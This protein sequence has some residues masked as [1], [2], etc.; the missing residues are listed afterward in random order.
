MFRALGGIL[1]K[2]TPSVVKNKTYLINDG[3]FHTLL[4]LELQLHIYSFLN[5][6]ESATA[7]PTCVLFN[8]LHSHHQ[9]KAFLKKLTNSADEAKHNEVIKLAKQIH[10]HKTEIADNRFFSN[11]LRTRFDLACDYYHFGDVEKGRKYLWEY[12]KR[13]NGKQSLYYNIHEYGQKLFRESV[14]TN[15]KF[16]GSLATEVFYLLISVQ[17]DETKKDKSWSA[18]WPEMELML[19][20]NF[21]C[22]LYKSERYSEAL[23]YFDNII[24]DNT[25][26]KNQ[27]TYRQS[28]LWRGMLHFDQKNHVQARQDFESY[29]SLC[30]HGEKGYLSAVKYLSFIK[31]AENEPQNMKLNK[32]G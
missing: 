15:D 26:Q 11:N 2:K 30:Q 13:I 10:Q 24:H 7:A 22:C 17:H 3:L 5:L 25:R 20:H 18:Y 29:I 21:A 8:E 23:M 4:P 32:L 19:Y 31:E 27:R 6:D 28:Y 9:K 12:L 14:E 1:S 16:K